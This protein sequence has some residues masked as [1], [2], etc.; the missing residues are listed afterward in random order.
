MSQGAS[1]H[2]TG[3]KQNAPAQEAE[4]SVLDAEYT[5]PLRD[6]ASP[7]L[8]IRE[9]SPHATGMREGTRCG[10]SWVREALVA[11]LPTIH[12]FSSHWCLCCEATEM[13]R[14]GL[15]GGNVRDGT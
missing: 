11:H 8:L 6:T 5:D 3:R 9:T 2:L 12:S 10:L 7:L 13:E 14:K 15:S 1:L 4:Q